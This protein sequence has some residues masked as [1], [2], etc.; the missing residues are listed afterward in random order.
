MY[1]NGIA[2]PCATR[3]K[4][5]IETWD[6]LKYQNLYALMQI[7][8]RINRNMRCIEIG[9]AVANGF[10]GVEINRNMRC[11]EITQRFG[12]KKLAAQINR[13]MR[14]IEIVKTS[15]EIASSIR[16]IETWDVLKWG[17]IARIN[18][19]IQINRKR[20]PD[21]NSSVSD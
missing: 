17:R 2:P 7:L 1:W 10:H 9:M 12:R 13:N 6:V 3:T 14:C 5:L 19:I 21:R 8:F 15:M 4:W 20:L 11:I 16:L 18:V